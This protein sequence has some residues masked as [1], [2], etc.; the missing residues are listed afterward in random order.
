MVCVWEKEGEI[1]SIQF[2]FEKLL[3]SLLS[4]PE[5]LP[6]VRLGTNP[7]AYVACD[8]ALAYAAAFCWGQ[9]QTCKRNV[10]SS[11]RWTGFVHNLSEE[12][13]GVRL[14]ELY[15]ETRDKADA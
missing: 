13:K 9:Q 10:M 8:R 4:P 15:D 12:G 14:F 2:S 7:I 11:H 6:S 1:K 3:I 5:A